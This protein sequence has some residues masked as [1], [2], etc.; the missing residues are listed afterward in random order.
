MQIDYK[1][2][3]KIRYDVKCVGYVEAGRL[4]HIL[5]SIH[6]PDLIASKAAARTSTQDKVRDG[7]FEALTR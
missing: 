5:P 4:H 3:E 1:E 7:L 6:L 2:Q